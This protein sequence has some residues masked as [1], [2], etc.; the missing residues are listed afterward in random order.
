MSEDC[1]EE[2]MAALMKA[3]LAGDEVAY[4][5]FLRSGGDLVRRV[6]RR[7]VSSGSVVSVEDIVQ[8][9]LLAVHLKRHT[10]R[11][12]EPILPWLLTIARYKTVDAFRRRGVRMMVP[13]DDMAD[14]LALPE[15]GAELEDAR[16]IERVVGSLSD[17]QQ[18]VL[19]SIA[20][21]GRTIRETANMLEMK[22]TAVRVA[23]HRGLT[24]IAA[25]YGRQT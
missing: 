16:H 18:K 14:V 22:E 19:R 23:F 13:I 11:S 10:W 25:R 15:S 12:A 1:A 5:D 8:E 3:A 21:E 20:I 9:T 24:A 2:R 7:R 4:T 17:G 6:T